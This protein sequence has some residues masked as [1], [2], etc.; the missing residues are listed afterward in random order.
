MNEQTSCWHFLFSKIPSRSGSWL[1]RGA[2]RPCCDFLVPFNSRRRNISRSHTLLALNIFFC[3]S[4]PNFC[5]SPSFSQHLH[6]L[7][8]SPI[9][10]YSSLHI[11]H[12]LVN[13]LSILLCSLY[14]LLTSYRAC[15]PSPPASK[16]SPYDQLNLLHFTATA[17]MC[18]TAI[19]L[20]QA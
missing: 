19:H 11:T 8:T 14:L 20:Q 2:D 15:S 9:L 5:P 3:L 4:A 10:R 7:S 18:L 12:F 1:L 16:D 17:Y 6:I 13:C